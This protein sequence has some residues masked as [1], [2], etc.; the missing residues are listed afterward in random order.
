MTICRGGR[1]VT[2]ARAFGR[3]L[4]IASLP[5]PVSRLS[6][7]ARF[8]R[9]LRKHPSPIPLRLPPSPIPHPPSPITYPLIPITYPFT[10][11]TSHFILHPSNT[12]LQ[13]PIREFP[14]TQTSLIVHFGSSS[15]LGLWAFEII[16]KTTNDLQGFRAA[17]FTSD[18]LHIYIK[19]SIIHP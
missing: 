17:F 2:V 7:P 15:R 4:E 12:S 5:Q 10:F 11:R 6:V 8:R 16:L 14:S 19:D 18:S 3:G 9:T 13:D 1:G